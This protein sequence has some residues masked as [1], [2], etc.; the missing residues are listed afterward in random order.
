[1]ASRGGSGRGELLFLGAGA[2]LLAWLANRQPAGAT[3]PPDLVPPPREGTGTNTGIAR[4]QTRLGALGYD[5]GPV[6]GTMTA[7]TGYAIQNFQSDFHIPITRVLD[8]GTMQQIDAQYDAIAARTGA[9]A[10]SDYS[11]FY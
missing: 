6:N 8:T 5:P 9:Q 11:D 3:A 4:Y 1:M 2:A 7:Q 10:T